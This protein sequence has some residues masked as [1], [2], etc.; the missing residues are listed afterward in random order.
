[1][2]FPPVKSFYVYPGLVLFYANV[3]VVFHSAVVTAT[4]QPNNINITV[5]AVIAFGD[6]M[7]DPG[8]NDYIITKVKAN[9]KPYGRDFFEGKPTG[10][11]SDGKIL[12]DF[13]V[14]N[15]GVKELLPPYLDPNLQLE[16]LLTGVSFA[17]AGAGYDHVTNIIASVLSLE[18]QL[19]MFKDYIEK[20]KVAVGEERTALVL[21]KSIFL[22][23]MGSNDVSERYSVTAFRRFHY[24]INEYTSMMVN[25]SSKFQKELYQLGARRIGVFSLNPV[26]CLPLQRTI[27]GGT[28]RVCAES[29]NQ[30]AMIFNSKLSSAMKDLNKQLPEAR[31]VYL[32]IY[33]E[34]LPYIQ[35]P[36]LF[37]FE[38]EDEG[39]CGIFNV[40]SGPLCN[41]FQLKICTDASKYVFW[42]ALLTNYRKELL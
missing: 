7:L 32:D 39:C 26:G 12:S 24:D 27:N 37:G 11:F 8:N 41:P 20:L 6:S 34:T 33:F 30:A 13:F 2:K 4:S 28:E 36:S 35:S 23:S 18:D 10:R 16:D 17:S 5:P 42:D 40:E 3:I 38:V 22:L 25:E 31:L 1:M 14:E 19:E 9:F 29:V 15:A 21:A